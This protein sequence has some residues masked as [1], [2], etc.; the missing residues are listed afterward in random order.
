MLENFFR[1][2]EDN[3][4]RQDNN[5]VQRN[6]VKNFLAESFNNEWSEHLFLK[7]ICPIDNEMLDLKDAIEKIDNEIFDFTNKYLSELDFNFLVQLVR[8]NFKENICAYFK[9]DVPWPI[10]NSYITLFSYNIERICLKKIH[11]E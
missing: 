5:V 9:V 10:I 6:T 7:N 2:G 11:E 1:D 3:N 4:V 8:N